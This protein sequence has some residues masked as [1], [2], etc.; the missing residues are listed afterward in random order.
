MAAKDPQIASL[1][2]NLS[3]ASLFILSGSHI[4]SITYHPDLYRVFQHPSI[5]T[6]IVPTA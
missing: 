4:L 3:L 1:I 6:I 2:N 5:R